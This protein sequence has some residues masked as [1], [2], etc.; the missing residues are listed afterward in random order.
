MAL[1][2]RRNTSGRVGRADFAWTVEHV[3]GI[4]LRPEMVGGGWGKAMGPVPERGM[5]VPARLPALPACLPACLPAPPAAS[6]PPPPSDPLYPAPLQVDVLFY[7]FGEPA[8][9]STAAATGGASSSGGSGSSKEDTTLNVN[10]M[11]QV[12]NRHYTTG[13]N[14]SYQ[15][16]KP[17]GGKSYLECV[18]DCVAKTKGGG[19]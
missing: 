14:I 13:L 16:N 10:Y 3:L 12:M 6:V 9:G 15:F 17:T 8:P 7:L 11:Y 2:F 19:M 1:E 4:K 18:R 5:C